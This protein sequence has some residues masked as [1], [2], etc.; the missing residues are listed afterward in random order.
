MLPRIPFHDL[1]TGFLGVLLLALLAILFGCATPTLSPMTDKE[2][3]ILRCRA[4]AERICGTHPMS[5]R[6]RTAAQQECA[7]LVGYSVKRDTL[8]KRGG[9]CKP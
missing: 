9:E 5:F 4:S 6:C 3:D 2:R 8:V 7:A 1:V